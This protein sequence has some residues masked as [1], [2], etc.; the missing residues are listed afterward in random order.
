[1]PFLSYAQNCEDVILYRALRHVG[2]GFYIDVGAADPMSHSVT[3]AFYERG[4]R[5][6]NVEPNPWFFARLTGERPRDINIQ[7]AVSD[8]TGVAPFYFVGG[9]TGLSTLNSDMELASAFCAPPQL[10][11]RLA[12]SRRCAPCATGGDGGVEGRRIG[13]DGGCVSAHAG[14]RRGTVPAAGDG[15]RGL[16]RDR[17][18]GDKGRSGLAEKGN[19]FPACEYLLAADA[20]PACCSLSLQEGVKTSWPPRFNR[21]RW[22]KTSKQTPEV[23]QAAADGRP[24]RPAQH[25]SERTPRPSSQCGFDPTLGP[26]HRSGPVLNPSP[27]DAPGNRRRTG[28]GSRPRRDCTRPRQTYLPWTTV[29]MIAAASRLP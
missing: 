3:R 28:S 21:P 16:A 24:S 27:S 26:R 12:A 9:N 29:S 14:R 8:I 25:P 10:V 13:A 17:T 19:R 11:R 7:A 2:P 4:W 5:G 1:V 22:S 18:R 6:V 23:P 15:A 20:A